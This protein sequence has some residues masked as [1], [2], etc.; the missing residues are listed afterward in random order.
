MWFRLGWY[1]SLLSYCRILLPTR[2]QEQVSCPLDTPE[3]GAKSVQ[4]IPGDRHHVPEA[5]SSPKVQDYSDWYRGGRVDRQ[6]KKEGKVVSEGFYIGSRR[7]SSIMYVLEAALSAQSSALL[8][9]QIWRSVVDVW[10][11]SSG[12]RNKR[13]TQKCHIES[14]LTLNHPAYKNSPTPDCRR[15]PLINF[16]QFVV[17]TMHRPV[18]PSL[19]CKRTAIVRKA[20]QTPLDS[21]ATFQVPEYGPSLATERVSPCH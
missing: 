5:C 8:V 9:V 2:V 13:T 20:G 7:V 1:R 21:L 17:H 18:G 15:T 14:P 6:K 11:N 16:Y 19:A 4:I 12:G 10:I 3:P